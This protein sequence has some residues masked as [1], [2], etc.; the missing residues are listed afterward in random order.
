M[1]RIKITNNRYIGNDEPCFVVAEIGINH[2]GDINLAKKMIDMAKECGVDAVKFQTFKAKEFVSSPDETY[3]YK[4]QGRE[5]TESMLEMF[6]KYEFSEE[7]LPIIKVGS[8]DL[9]N[10][11]LLKYYASK[12]KTLI[13]STG[14]AFISEIEDAVEIIRQK[15]NNDLVVLHCISSYPSEP[16]EVN[17]KK[18]LTIKQAFNV[19]VGFSDH[20]IGNIAATAAI[21]LGAKVIEKHFTLD[22]NLPGPDHWFSSD[23]KELSQLVQAIRYTEKSLGNYVIKPTPKELKMRK[24]ARRS[25]VAARDIKKGEIITPEAL[26]VKRPGTGLPPKFINYILKKEA[27]INIKKNELITFEK[28]C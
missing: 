8:D 17:L 14:M 5:V 4:S 15:G 2:N 23:P 3:T 20:T 24:I 27:K 1:H 18:M 10:L 26:C 16:E 6:E 25:I 12:N 13:I 19:V 9:T 22:K 11:E 28:I 21:A 7:D